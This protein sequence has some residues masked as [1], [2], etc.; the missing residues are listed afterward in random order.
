MAKSSVQIFEA[1]TLKA[2]E[3]EF[4]I[5]NENADET[6][7]LLKGVAKNLV[8]QIVSRRKAR[9]KLP[10]LY[11]N[12]Q[13][14]YPNS[15]SLEQSSSEKTALFKS[16][17]FDGKI[18]IDLTTGF[19]IDSYFFSK[20][21]EK[22][23]LIEKQ[24]E[25]IAK[26]AFNFNLFNINNVEF[27]KDDSVNFINNY[28]Q[29]ISLIYLDP[30]RRDT[31]GGKVFKISDCEPNLL[32]ILP[33]LSEKA[34]SIL[35]KFSPLLDISQAISEI[36]SVKTVYVIA[37]DNECK[38]LLFHI[39]PL[40]SKPSISA[41]NIKKDKIETFDFVYEHE[42]EL[43]AHYSLPQKY[44]YEPNAAIM[45]SGGFKSVG[46]KYNILKLHQNTHLYTS[47]LLIDNF[48]GRVFE[49]IEIIK[50]DYKSVK[51]IIPNM[52]GNLT[53]RNFP[54][55]TKVLKK[56]LKIIDG[57]DYYLFATTLLDNKNCV[58]ICKKV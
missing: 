43:T 44:I 27:V 7:L 54:T 38:E 11:N 6:K 30:A 4:V 45:K 15:L 58:I 51:T 10:F 12:P 5:A 34:D 46:E 57:G 18:F 23:Y 42:K 17:L 41:I 8:N 20:R 32:E 52:K 29:K 22:C 19:G 24:E 39:T 26:T 2:E 9:L 49:I 40:N 14:I 31:K 25:L 53:L 13:V 56:K 1:M 21:F 37:V 16:S 55:T 35:V 50:P 3:V 36:K 33:I 47:N 28:S 48:Q